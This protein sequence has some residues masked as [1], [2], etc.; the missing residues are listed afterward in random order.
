MATDEFELPNNIKTARAL[1]RQVQQEFYRWKQPWI[2]QLLKNPSPSFGSAQGCYAKFKIPQDVFK[3][4]PNPTPKFE[5]SGAGDFIYEWTY[6]GDGKPDEGRAIPVK[7]VAPAHPHLVAHPP[8]QFCTPALRSENARMIDN[9]DAPFIPFPED[10]AFP[11]EGY[12]SLFDAVQWENDQQ[13]PDEEIIQFET[14]RRL[15]IDLGFSADLVEQ[16][17]QTMGFPPLRAS[18]ES[19]LLWAVSQR[20][21]LPVIW[22]DGLPSE[23]KPQLPPNFPY[24]PVST[25]PSSQIDAGMAKFCPNLNCLLLNCRIHVDS[26]WELRTPPVVPKQP[27]LTSGQLLLTSGLICGDECFRNINED[28]RMSDSFA[29]GPP[30]ALAVL[31]SLVSLEPDTIPC[32]L[33]VIC[34]M[35]CREV[36][37]RR[38]HMIDDSKVTAPPEQTHWQR[39]QKAKRCDFIN[40]SKPEDLQRACPASTQAHAPTRDATASNSR[41]VARGIVVVKKNVFVAGRG[42]I[43]RAQGPKSAVRPVNAVE[44][45][46]SAIQRSAWPAM[47]GGCINI[48]RMKLRDHLANAPMLPSNEGRSSAN[49]QQKFVVNKSTY[50]LGAFAAESM[51]IGDTLGEYVGELIDNVNETVGHRGVVQD[52]SGLNYCFGMGSVDATEVTTVDAQWLGNPTR[53]LNDSRPNPPNCEA[54]EVL[55]NGERRLAIRAMKPVRYG[56]ELTLSYG[57]RYWK[58]GEAQEEQNANLLEKVATITMLLHQ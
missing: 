18:N 19:G 22:G 48:F 10:P 12:L 55:V 58:E 38:Q 36:F 25:H 27:S 39:R 4:L 11:R 21:M 24:D 51:F 52:H 28:D 13:D 37:L 32:T 33:A 3:T 45:G 53:F 14:V 49:N 35:S 30:D 47:R 26:S 7:V 9:K 31:S 1:Y 50:G 54:V 43:L 41:S 5:D 20:D 2:T 42:V 29:D 56:D 6:D 44:K 46:A 16:I 40:R 57:M 8:Y 17:L 34:Q 23:R 15:H